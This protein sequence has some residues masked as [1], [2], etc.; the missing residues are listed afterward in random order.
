MIQLKI[1][2]ATNPMAAPRIAP[3]S[4]VITD[5]PES[6]VSRPNGRV[7][8]HT[9]GYT[10]LIHKPLHLK[11]S[12]LNLSD[13]RMKTTALLIDFQVHTWTSANALC[14]ACLQL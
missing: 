8:K 9:T 3:I 12:G 11:R 7:W 5:G 2:P 14:T 4:A 10:I 13:R 6:D 1:P